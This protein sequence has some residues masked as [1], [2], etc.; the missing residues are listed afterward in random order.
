MSVQKRIELQHKVLGL[1]KNEV[2]VALALELFHWQYHHNSVYQNW[3]NALNVKP[4]QVLTIEQIPFL[5]ISF[6]K[7]DVVKTLDFEPETVFKSSGTAQTS[8]SQHFVR[9]LD[10]YFKLSL[11]IFEEEIGELDDFVLLALLPNYLEKGN[12]SLIA[13]L[14]FFMQKTKKGSDFYL[15][16]FEVLRSKILEHQQQNV[17]LWGVAYSLMDFAEY[18][19]INHPN[20]IVFE[21][22]GMKGR[23]KELLK[24][25]LHSILTKNYGVPKIYSEYGMTEL[26]SQA[27]SKGN[28]IFDES[29]T[30]KI[31]IREVND[32][33]AIQRT[34]TGV[35]NVL[36]YGNIDSCCFIATDDLGIK[37]DFATF[38]ILG[39][40]DN[41]D[42]RGC[43]ML[44]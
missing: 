14:Q 25:E 11:S 19:S 12:S 24:E 20:L 2:D 1:K 32:P 44:V 8:D 6:F 30:L 10:W 18:C 15:Y 26:L 38:S 22:G 42:I 40:L 35:M 13:M 37:P 16:D 43:N 34:G 36:D 27:Y 33:F 17:I 5:P 39:R 41:S 3:V 29:K 4:Q 9:D 31:W 28:G 23:R 21:T 7:N